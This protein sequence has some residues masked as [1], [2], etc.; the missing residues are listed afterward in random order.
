M[1]EILGSGLARA[2]QALKIKAERKHKGARFEVWELSEAEYKRLCNIPDEDWK[3]EAFGWW[4]WGECIL[5][6]SPLYP[7]TVN[8]SKMLGYLDMDAIADLNKGED[9]EDMVDETY[10]TG[11]QYKSFTEW[12]SSVMGLSAERHIACVAISLAKANGLSLAGFIKQ[13]EP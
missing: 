10:Y 8:G 9:P 7:F 1:K 4:R 3:D 5:E 2:F 12:L 11:C 13:Y 6:G